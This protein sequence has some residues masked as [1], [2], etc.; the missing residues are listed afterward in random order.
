[1]SFLDELPPVRRFRLPFTRRRAFFHLDGIVYEALGPLGRRE[2]TGEELMLARDERGRGPGS[3]WVV[4]RLHHSLDQGSRRLLPCEAEQAMRLSHPGLLRLRQLAVHESRP[5]EKR[6][7][8]VL[9][10]VGGRSL[11]SV[12]AL[13]PVLGRKPLSVQ[14]A[15]QVAMQVADVLDYLHTRT[16]VCGGGGPPRHGDLC[17]SLL[18]LS[19]DGR[20]KLGGVGT[21]VSRQ[22]ARWEKRH[23]WADLVR[24]LRYAPPAALS[25]DAPGGFG[26]VYAL[27]V[28]LLEMWL[29]RPLEDIEGSWDWSEG[30]RWEAVE[31][32]LRRLRLPSG[33]DDVLRAA[34]RCEPSGRISTAA[35]LKDALRGYTRDRQEL[36]TELFWL[37]H[38]LPGRV[39]PWGVDPLYYLRGG[40]SGSWGDAGF[41]G[42]P[43]LR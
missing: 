31:R 28:V 12:L 26:D 1:M 7:Y 11:A 38:E 39:L 2:G 4:E 21:R 40:Y 43:F 16:N 5:Y 35:K 30:L 32:H 29:G 33:L 37:E 17:P 20:V 24:Q 8:A 23:G 42:K 22:V 25:R 19:P 15:C 34:L 27:A 9:E 36:A 14:A 18:W 41:D 13:S 3:L 10:Y 6:P